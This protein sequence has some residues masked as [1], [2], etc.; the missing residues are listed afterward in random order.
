LCRLIAIAVKLNQNP[1]LR[2]IPIE[3]LRLQEKTTRAIRRMQ[4]SMKQTASITPERPC[5]NLQAN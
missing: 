2:N 4:R 3:A 1:K 5:A